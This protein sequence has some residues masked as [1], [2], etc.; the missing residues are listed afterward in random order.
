MKLRNNSTV[1][2]LIPLFILGQ[3][4][5]LLP[6]FA[7]AN[8]ETR[9]DSCC[10]EGKGCKMFFHTGF[11]DDI[12]HTHKAGEWMFDYKYMHMEMNGLRDGTKDVPLRDVIPMSGTKYGFMMAPTKMTMDMHMFMAMYGA[13]DQLTVM[14]MVPYVENMMDMLMNMGMRDRPEPPMRTSGLSDIELR[15]IYKVTECLNASL[16]LSLPTGSIKEEFN[17]MRMRF[18]DPYDMQLGSGTFDL[19]PALTYNA[20][21]KDANWN[22][23]AQAQYNLHNGKNKYDYSLG[24]NVKLTCWLQRALGN[25]TPWLRL[26]YNNTGAIRGQDPEIQKLLDPVMGAPTPDADTGNYGGQRLDGLVG[27]GYTM[28]RFSFGVE[29]GMPFYQNLNGLQMEAKWVLTANIKVT[30]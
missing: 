5:C 25:F 13:T 7:S 4:F 19:K 21:S 24:D 9:H 29:G 14:A 23:G 10:H 2:F 3:F 30:F 17:T 18:R 15:G 26:A 6:A 27:L 22:W 20:L 8:K 1:T 28:G 11:G 12:Y 16:G